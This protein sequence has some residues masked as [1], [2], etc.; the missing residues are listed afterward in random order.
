LAGAAKA[1]RIP[2]LTSA[3]LPNNSLCCMIPF[4]TRTRKGVC[5]YFKVSIS[6][7][8]LLDQVNFQRSLLTT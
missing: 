8:H 3:L 1:I 5:F 2:A 6:P 4:S 7:V